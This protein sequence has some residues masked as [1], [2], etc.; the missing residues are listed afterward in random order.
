M[1]NVKVCKTLNSGSIPLLALNPFY[2]KSKPIKGKLNYLSFFIT[3]S[4]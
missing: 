3:Y 1:V 4:L 2:S